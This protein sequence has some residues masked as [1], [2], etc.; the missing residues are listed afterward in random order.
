MMM[1][2][3]WDVSGAVFGGKERQLKDKARGEC[4]EGNATAFW[5][6]LF[7]KCFGLDNICHVITLIAVYTGRKSGMS[8]MRDTWMDFTWV[9]CVL[10]SFYTG[11]KSRMST[12]LD[13]WMDYTWVCSVL[14]SFYFRFFFFLFFDWGFDRFR[15]HQGL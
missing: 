2:T 1:M 4:V 12:M 11:G 7:H 6:F 14:P 3:H 9:C 13:T 15:L 10:P 8:T 5:C